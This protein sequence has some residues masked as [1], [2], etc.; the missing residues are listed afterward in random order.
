M[1]EYPLIFINHG[2]AKSGVDI[3]LLS[4]LIL[5]IPVSMDSI[6][7]PVTPALPGPNALEAVHPPGRGGFRLAG[8]R[9]ARRDPGWFMVNN[10]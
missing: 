1:E 3:I 5:V 7:I 6:W 2:L 9:V 4:S 8:N 10:G